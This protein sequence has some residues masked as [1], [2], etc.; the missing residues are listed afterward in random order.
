MLDNV[1]EYDPDCK[2]GVPSRTDAPVCGSQSLCQG[3]LLEVIQVG[4]VGV[5]GTASPV[6][7]PQDTVD[8]RSSV[9]HAALVQVRP[10]NGS[11]L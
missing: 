6:Q 2:A 5:I 7:T 3:D 8:R 9:Q 1:A 4:T 11:A 10:K